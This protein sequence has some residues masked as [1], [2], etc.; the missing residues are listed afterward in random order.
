MSV[1]E[2]HSPTVEQLP[3]L[4]TELQSEVAQRAGLKHVTTLEKN[5]LPTKEDLEEERKHESFKKG[6]HNFDAHKLRHVETED[7]CMLP[8]S[9]DIA[10]EKTPQLAAEFDQSGLKHVETTVK[11][12]IEVIDKA[13]QN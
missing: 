5:V 6:I 1:P 11:T 13:E 3:K 10:V 7:K 12:N 2:T 9:N 8:S 4:P